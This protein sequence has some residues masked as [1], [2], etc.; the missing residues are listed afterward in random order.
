MDVDFGRTASDYSRHRAGFPEP[1]FDRLFRDGI[2]RQQDRILD[3][4]TG[5]G[6]LARGFARRGSRVTAL[7]P[8]RAMLA[9]AMRLAGEA[10]LHIRYIEAAAEQTGLPSHEFDLIAAGQC[11]HWFD[12]PRAAAEARRLLAQG[13]RLLIAHF[14]WLPL[15]GNVVEATEALIL[16]HNPQWDADGGTGIHDAWFAD[17]SAGGFHAIESF[18]FDIV[19]PYSH[20]AWLGRIRASAGVGAS[21]PQ[22]A[23]ARFDMAH[24]AMLERE[25]PADPLLIPHRVFAVYGSLPNA[26][27]E[28]A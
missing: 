14:D 22:D 1:F 11:W 16:E 28:V 5:T 6:T 8:S 17:L 12:R 26:S 20:A 15:A 27:G 18:S 4:G 13:G 23:L 2:V 19:V 21:L 24:R 10:G 9:Q 3:L 25:F 7:D